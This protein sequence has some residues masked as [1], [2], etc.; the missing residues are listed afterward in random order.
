M[1]L[2]LAFCK[3]NICLKW[4]QKTFMLMNTLC[5]VQ[6]MIPFFLCIPSLPM[7]SLRVMT[8][9]EKKEC[10][11]SL[12]SNA[13]IETN[14]CLTEV[15]Q[16]IS[17]ISEAA[18]NELWS[19]YHCRYEKKSYLLFKFS[20]FNSQT[21]TCIS[22]CRRFLSSLTHWSHITHTHIFCLVAEANQ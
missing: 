1:L 20:N 12:D 19:K 3:Q 13:W 22:W 14:Y 9:Q 18:S 6:P 10:I 17:Q 8:H 16:S 15:H 4:K 11:N 7:L 21:S 5:S 2:A